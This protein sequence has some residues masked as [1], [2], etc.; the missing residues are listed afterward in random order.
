MNE[1][2]PNNRQR[3]VPANHR[4][5][6]AQLLPQKSRMGVVSLLYHHQP[7]SQPIAVENR[8]SRWLGTDEQ[9]YLRKL[10]LTKEWVPL[11]KGWLDVAGMLMIRNEEDKEGTEKIIEVALNAEPMTY[12]FA[13]VRPKESAQFEP[14][15]LH[16]LRLR[17]L[18][19]PAKCTLALIPR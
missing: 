15:N 5:Q 17:C 12:G 19:G 18:A 3:I 1:Q 10:T 9:P 11:D 6:P 4:T 16:S 2:Q 7:G 8:F 14:D 13:K